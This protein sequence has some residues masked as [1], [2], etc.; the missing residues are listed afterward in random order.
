MLTQDVVKLAQAQELLYAS[1]TRSVLLVFQAMDAAGKDG[2]IKHV[3]SGINP[4]G[5]QVYSFKKPSTEELDHDFCGAAQS[6]ARTRADRHLQPFVLRR[7][8]GRRSHPADSGIA[9]IARAEKFG[10][11]FWNERYESI[12]EFKAHLNRRTAPPSSSSF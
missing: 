6:D 4:Q 2:T 5:C 12:N 7:S 9:A 1:D 3:M 11:Q 10:K 8:I